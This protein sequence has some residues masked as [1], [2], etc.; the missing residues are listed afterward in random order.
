M[1]NGRLH[2]LPSLE[3]STLLSSQ[4]L[5]LA[6]MDDLNVG[7]ATIHTAIAQIHHYL[8]GNAAHIF[9]RDAGLLQL[10]CENVAVVRVTRE[11]PRAY[12]QTTLV[13]QGDT[14]LD[15]VSMPLVNWLFRTLCDA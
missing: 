2:G 15:A 8:F 1:T 10:C 12:Y 14:G 9:E 7:I 6:A 5:V 3:P 11:G 13:R 4:R